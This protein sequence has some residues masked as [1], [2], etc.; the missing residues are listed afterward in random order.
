MKEFDKLND[1]IKKKNSENSELK[2]IYL[3]EKI[4]INEELKFHNTLTIINNFE[5]KKDDNLIHKIK[6]AK[7]RVLI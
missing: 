1:E 2:E 4:K 7:N 6:K 5:I 3:K